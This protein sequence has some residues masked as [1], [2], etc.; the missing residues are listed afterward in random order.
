MVGDKHDTG[1]Q[2]KRVSQRGDS[3]CWAF[4]DPCGT[5]GQEP[6]HSV[7]AS[8][9][10]PQME[11]QRLA[12]EKQMR[13][14]AERTRDELERRLLQMKEE[15]TMANEALV[16]AEGSGA[17]GA[18]QGLAQLAG[19]RPPGDHR[20]ATFALTFQLK[21][22]SAFPFHLCWQKQI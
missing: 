10:H 5:A 6:L 13:E 18:A 15:A 3:G 19:V 7:T 14:E 4:L 2:K 17:W 12:R 9:P 21:K 22:N 11:R 16:I 8:T 20:L 1:Y